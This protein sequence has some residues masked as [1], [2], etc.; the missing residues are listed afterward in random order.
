MK[1][2][3]Q[4]LVSFIISYKM[5]T[6]VRFCLPY[7]PLKHD[8]IAFKMNIISIGKCIVNIDVVNDVTCMLQSVITYVVIRFLLHY[9]ID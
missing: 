5:T 4:A 3:K 7:D 1:F 2:M 6:R 8:F 9:V